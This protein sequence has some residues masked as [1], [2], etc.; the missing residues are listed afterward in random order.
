MMAYGGASR[1]MAGSRGGSLCR[2]N[3]TTTTTSTSG[4][5]TT[6][7]TAA[8]SNQQQIQRP[9]PAEYSP[10]GTPTLAAAAAAAAIEGSI[11]YPSSSSSSS[12]VIGQQ[13]TLANSYASPQQNS[14][15]GGGNNN[16]QV[17]SFGFTQEQVACVCEVSLF[18]FFLCQKCLF[19]LFFPTRLF[20]NYNVMVYKISFSID[21]P[22][23]ERKWKGGS[24]RKRSILR[25]FIRK[26]NRMLTRKLWLVYIICNEIK[27][28]CL[29]MYLFRFLKKK[30]FLHS[31]YNTKKKNLFI[32]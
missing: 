9:T 32:K 23:S 31:I 18:F 1:P 8:T 24:T 14:P 16:G 3:A 19:C 20:I 27:I 4:S 29:T 15:I 2:G 21:A 17:P 7:T 28:T 26:I 10:Q 13:H 6:T 30:S 22:G 5:S 11:P 12:S 25:P